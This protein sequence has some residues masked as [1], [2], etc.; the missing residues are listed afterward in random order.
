MA[1]LLR[2]LPLAGRS[3]LRAPLFTAAAVLTLALGIGANTAIFSVVHGV[4][5]KPLP[6]ASEERLLGL[7]NTAPGLGFELLNQSPALY[8][9]YRD[10][11]VKKSEL[12]LFLRPTVVRGAGTGQP[13]L[14]SA[15]V[16]LGTTEKPGA[17]P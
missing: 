5:L 7:W 6:Y 4:L 16:P 9:S 14:A 17:T 12:V 13:A 3:L 1:S 11:A 8:F 15:A 2:N 10:D